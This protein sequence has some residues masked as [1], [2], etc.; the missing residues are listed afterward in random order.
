MGARLS[1]A[2]RHRTVAVRAPHSAPV[3]T[4]GFGLSAHTLMLTLTIPNSIHSIMN[5][6][7]DLIPV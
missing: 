1:P 2:A 4:G 6:K 5:I 7:I 3:S